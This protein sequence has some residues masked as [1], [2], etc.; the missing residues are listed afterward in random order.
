[1]RFLV[2]LGH[3]PLLCYV[4]FN[5]LLNSLFELI[6]P[7]Q[8]VLESTPAESVLRSAIMTVI[9]VVIVRAVTRRRIFWRT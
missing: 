4:L 3:N 1:M 2:D 6:H 8:P 5:G 7:L 9:T